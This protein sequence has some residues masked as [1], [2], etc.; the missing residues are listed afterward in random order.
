[1]TINDGRN[2]GGPMPQQRQRP[3][4]NGRP[5][6]PNGPPSDMYGQM[7][8]PPQQRPPPQNGPRGPPPR[9]ASH[10]NFG[11][12]RN[13][14]QQSPPPQGFQRQGPPPPVR[15]YGGPQNE[16][17]VEEQFGN[18]EDEGQQYGNGRMPPAQERLQPSGNVIQ[19]SMTMP[20]REHDLISPHPP[21]PYH[22]QPSVPPQY[23]QYSFN[24]PRG[25]GQLPPPMMEHNIP[26]AGYEHQGGHNMPG[27]LNPEQYESQ[28]NEVLDSYYDGDQQYDG[29]TEPLYEGPRETGVTPPGPPRNQIEGFDPSW[30]KPQPNSNFAFAAHAH[31]SR[32]QPDLRDSGFSVG[33]QNA[34]VEMPGDVPPVPSAMAFP[35]QAD[36]PQI[37]R[38]KTPA[39]ESGHMPRRSPPNQM[40]PQFPPPQFPLPQQPPLP[41]V[42]TPQNDI[43]YFPQPPNDQQYPAQQYPPQMPPQN[44]L[45]Q[46]HPQYDTPQQQYHSRVQSGDTLPYHPLPQNYNRDSNADALP[47]HPA[48]VRP[49]L[50]QDQN[51]HMGQV[52][53]GPPPPVRQYA[54]RDSIDSRSSQAPPPKGPIT[55]E[56]LG[57]IIQLAKSAPNDQNLQLTLVKKY[58]EAA[59][60]LSDESGRAD[61]RMAKKNRESYI[62]DAH[63]LL[64]K[65]ANGVSICGFTTRPSWWLV[66]I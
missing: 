42:N 30:E 34:L 13:G 49:G 39:P 57:K 50:M 43:K 54:P 47:E 19:R 3:P 46:Q 16:A 40:P 59:D 55:R 23:E 65:L 45:Q 37:L 5:P 22:R 66:L 9:M 14:H 38:V 10:G 24:G 15:N 29:P 41:N 44:S 21:G 7:G 27:G 61:A 8:R 48:P 31:R 25:Y 60:V 20:A 35:V 32:S 1:M 11:V 63:K 28:V 33:S 56:E 2:Y 18:Y 17:W 6:P 12:L 58:I 4:P 51:L 64:K 26:P 52:S 53:P 62:F 36:L